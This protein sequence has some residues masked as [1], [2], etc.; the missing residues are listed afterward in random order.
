[1]DWARA[2]RGDAGDYSPGGENFD[3]IC[4]FFLLHEVPEEKKTAVVNNMLR[5]L[6]PGKKLVFVD[7]CNPKPWQPIRYILK[8]VNHFLEPFAEA[9]W[10]KEIRDY[11]KDPGRFVWRLKTLFAGVYQCVVVEHGGEHT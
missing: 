11:A 8:F 1:M 9:L 6:A 7:Y 10:K 5:H 2:V 3:V 4:S